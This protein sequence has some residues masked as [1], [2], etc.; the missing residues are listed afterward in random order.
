M[1]DHTS[2]NLPRGQVQLHSRFLEMVQS[3]EV[4][5][6][7]RHGESKDFQFQPL[8]MADLSIRKWMWFPLREPVVECAQS[9]PLSFPCLRAVRWDPQALLE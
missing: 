1:D 3:S 5:W 8:L 6:T 9:P 4:T 2:C 7:K